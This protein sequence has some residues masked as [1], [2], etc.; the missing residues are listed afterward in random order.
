MADVLD[1]HVDVDAGLGQRVEDRARDARPVRHGDDRDLG[2]VPV[3]GQP[4]DLVAL[5][6]ERILLDERAGGVLERAED[7]DD[8]A[9]D[10]AELDGADLHDLGALV[11]ELEHLLVADDRQLAGAGDEPRVGRVDALDVGEDLAAVGA[12][13]GRQRDRGRVAAAA[14]EGRDLASSSARALWPWKPATMTTLPAVELGADAARLDA[15]D[16]G[17]AVAA[18]GGDAGLRAGQA[19]G[20][21][22]EAVEGHRQEGRALV[23]AGGEQDVELARVGLVGDRRREAEQLV[24]GVAHR[25]HDDDEVAARRRARARSAGRRA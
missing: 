25:R 2:D 20:R 6:H 17:A 5:L 4:A 15:G 11:G 19:D 1:D 14:A 24:G 7:L 9:V 13:A 12:E 22:A 3:V 10:P 23:L 8:D 21:H 18:V 16:P